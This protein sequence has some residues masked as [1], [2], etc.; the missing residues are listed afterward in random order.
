M[1]CIGGRIGFAS[2]E[3][4]AIAICIDEL[5]GTLPRPIDV[6]TRHVSRCYVAGIQ[7]EQKYAACKLNRAS[8]K[9]DPRQNRDP[10]REHSASNVLAGRDVENTTPL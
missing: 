2:I 6:D 4:N 1:I 8:R 5:A 10:H 9:N 7:N 3:K